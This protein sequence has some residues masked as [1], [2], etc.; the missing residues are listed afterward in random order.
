MSRKTPRKGQRRVDLDLMRVIA[1]FLVIFNHSPGYTL[2]MT[3]KTVWETWIYM[4]L[5]M[6]TRMNVPLFFMISGTLLLTDRQ[7]GYREILSK[8]FLRIARDLILFTFAM[9]LIYVL[10]NGHF[11]NWGQLIRYI[12]SGPDEIGGHSSWFLY[13]YLGYLL[14]LPF[15]RRITKGMTKADFIMLLSVHII[16]SSVVPMVN[17]FLSAHGITK[18]EISGDFMNALHVALAKVMFYPLIGYYIDRKVDLKGLKSKRLVLLCLTMAGGILVS[19]ACTYYQGTHGEKVFTQDYVQLFDYVTTI[20][21]FILIKSICAEHENFANHPYLV[22]AVRI[23]APLTLGIYLMHP[24]LQAVLF[25]GFSSILAAHVPAIFVSVLWSLV[26]FF[27][28]GNLTYLLRK[29]PALK[30]LL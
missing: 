10:R 5:A 29:V 25:E 13:C 9:Y 2:Y 7:E 19:C 26:S 4:I 23:I 12:I 15:L 11:W 18:V 8:R 24:I 3:A 6:I 22:E 30:K 17:L 20:C 27:L 14:C 21:A 28:C 1:C 16:F